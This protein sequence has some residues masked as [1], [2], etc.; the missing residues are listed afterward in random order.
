MKIHS[1]W[2]EAKRVQRPESWDLSR[3]AWEVNI[4]VTLLILRPDAVSGGP[5]PQ[6]S[7]HHKGQLFWAGITDPG[8]LPLWLREPVWGR[9]RWRSPQ[10]GGA[11]SRDGP[12]PGWETMDSV[13]THASSSGCSSPLSPILNVTFCFPKI[14]IL[15]LA[16]KFHLHVG[17][18]ADQEL[19]LTVTVPFAGNWTRLHKASGW[20]QHAAW[21]PRLDL[22]FLE[23]L[24]S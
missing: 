14:N 7:A 16:V 2:Q 1:P 15:S 4:W 5:H 20:C 19:R 17:F 9:Q 23:G 10:P 12:H 13:M 24:T 3:S 6:P 21:V 11:F 22:H 8:T 18:L